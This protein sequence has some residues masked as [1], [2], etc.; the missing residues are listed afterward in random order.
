MN[1]A[2]L[3]WLARGIVSAVVLSALW[4]AH[5]AHE[6]DQQPRQPRLAAAQPATATSPAR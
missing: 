6:A 2:I 1:S 4:L 3:T 5:A